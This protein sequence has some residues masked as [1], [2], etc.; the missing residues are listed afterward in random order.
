MMIHRRTCG[1][2]RTAA[3]MKSAKSC[4]RVGAHSGLRP[5][6]DHAGKPLTLRTGSILFARALATARLTAAG[7]R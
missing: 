3:A 6:F 5:P 2:F 1:Y 7:Q 4:G